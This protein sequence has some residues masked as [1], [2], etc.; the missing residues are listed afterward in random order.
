MTDAEKTLTY[1]GRRVTTKGTLAY[2]YAHPDGELRGYAKP[3]ITGAKVGTQI[4]VT[5]ADDGQ[6]W[7]TGPQAP[8]ASGQMS[9]GDPHLLQ[10]SI[11]EK[12]DL[13]RATQIREQQRI[14]KAGAD[15]LRTHLA[16][17]R[18]RL[19]TMSPDRRAAAV[20]WILTFLLGDTR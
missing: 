17:V 19:R 15:P 6:F 18:D 20:G 3:L 14:I 10:W 7:A 16:P 9:A 2:F 8:R 11:D 12:G 13:A 5:A 1:A 4:T